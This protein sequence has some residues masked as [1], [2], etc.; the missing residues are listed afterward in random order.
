MEDREPAKYHMDERGRL[1]D[2]KG[3]AVDLPRATVFS[4]SI[5][6][7]KA[8]KK[9]IQNHSRYLSLTKQSTTAFTRDQFYDPNLPK[10]HKKAKTALSGFLFGDET[11]SIEPIRAD[12]VPTVEWWDRALVEG[13]SYCKELTQ[14]EVEAVVARGGD[15]RAELERRAKTASF[16][17]KL[18]A[19]TMEIDRPV[20]MYSAPINTTSHS[21]IMHL[22]DKEKRKLRRLKRS[23]KLLELR[24]KVKLGLIPA[25]AQKIKLNTMMKLLAKEV[26][27][28]P[29]KTEQEVMAKY[30]ERL[31]DHEQRNEARKLTKPQRKE[32]EMRRLR[33]DSARES[34]TAV[35]RIARLQHKKNL[36]KV[37][38][39]AEQL[40]LVGVCIK[41]P[42]ELPTVLV[43]EGGRHALKLYKK[44]L[45]NR[46]KWDLEEPQGSCDMVWEAEI[47]DPV[48]GR[49]SYKETATELEAR[50]LLAERKCEH[51]L[52]LVLSWKPPTDL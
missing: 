10:P 28:D 15:V 3:R 31:R 35:F 25:P 37:M 8:A 45:L 18:T 44:L 52:D 33:R 27:C 6:Q 32:R 16:N 39:N 26:S 9:G 42:E 43:V 46:V 19:V 24:E 36:F 41:L 29:S 17:V 13:D 12:I 40:A 34:R 20:P 51:Y 7:E 14:K 5:N 23:K 22:T 2:D 47:K 11:R 48:F 21:V 30:N 38:K 49:F 4:L 1:L 50:Q